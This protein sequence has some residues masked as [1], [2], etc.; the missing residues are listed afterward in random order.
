MLLVF[1]VDLIGKGA[2]GL[3]PGCFGVA[4]KDVV[5]QLAVML[6]GSE[7]SPGQSLTLPNRP[8]L[9]DQAAPALTPGSF[10]FAQD[11][12]QRRLVH[13]PVALARS[14][15]QHDIIGWKR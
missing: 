8:A 15:P 4:P 9:Q 1:N 5:S 12:P 7:A 10:D 2:P 11:D 13:N 14:A 6:N 3:A